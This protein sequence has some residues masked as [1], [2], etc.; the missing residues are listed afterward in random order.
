MRTDQSSTPQLLVRAP[1]AARMLDIS[2]TTLWHLV[3][4]GSLDVVRL[5]D[6]IVRFRTADLEARVAP[7]PSSWPQSLTGAQEAR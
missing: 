2:E 4:N 5:S 1:R 3:A 6:R 7:Q